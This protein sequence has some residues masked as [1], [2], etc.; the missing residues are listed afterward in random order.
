MPP[1]CGVGGGPS[2]ALRFAGMPIIDGKNVS[3]DEA[4]LLG[5][6]PECGQPLIPKTA[7]AHAAD[8]WFGR[9]PNDPWLSEEARRRYKLIIDFAAARYNPLAARSET[10]TDADR[11]S[12]TPSDRP[13]KTFLDYVALGIILEAASAFWRGDS[14]SRVVA[15]FIGGGAVLLAR[16]KWERLE[17]TLG[18]RFASTARNVATDFRWW[19]APLLLLSLYVGT[20]TFIGAVKRAWYPSQQIPTT[21]TTSHQLSW[22]QTVTLL[23]GFR[24]ARRA[25]I[26]AGWGPRPLPPETCC[27][28]ITST[29]AN[30]LFHG[31][32]EE[33]AKGAGCDVAQPPSVDLTNADAT[34][35]P[36][37]TIRPYVLIRAAWPEGPPPTKNPDDPQTAKYW[38]ET[39]A[40]QEAEIL[41]N[42]FITIRLP[43]KRSKILKADDDPAQVY[44]ELGDIAPWK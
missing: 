7:R 27:V 5:R 14:F 35:T 4:M 44:I 10:K 3:P 16:Y 20:P 32:L 1:V 28:S 18:E 19:I 17:A 15:G 41:L 9:D 24:A 31:Q 8:H 13:V 36:T 40:N 38:R 21:V 34:P 42:A 2:S 43:A 37:P 22:D 33:L 23:D 12:S 6:C 11:M 30:N 25:F 26:D 39:Y 29:P